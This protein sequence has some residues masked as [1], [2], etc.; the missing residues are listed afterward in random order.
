MFSASRGSLTGQSPK[1]YLLSNSF[2][3]DFPPCPA[4]HKHPSGTS[5]P[6]PP[7]SLGTPSEDTQNFPFLRDQLGQ[8]V[9]KALQARWEKQPERAELQ[10]PQGKGCLKVETPRGQGL[11]GTVASSPSRLFW[12]LGC[13]LLQTGFKAT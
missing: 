13:T 4:P 9:E 11:W 2:F 12:G 8:E 6:R 10:E 3:T 5:Q 1:G 7:K